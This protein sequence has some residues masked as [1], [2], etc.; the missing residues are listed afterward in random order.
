MGEFHYCRYDCRKW[1]VELQKMKAGGVTVLST[2]LL[3]I[4]HEEEESVFDFSGNWDLRQ[5]VLLAQKVGLEVMLRIGGWAH[6]EC[7]NGG[8]PDWLVQKGI[9]LRQNDPAYLRQIRKWYGEIYQQ[10]QGLM[11]YEGGNIMGIQLDNELTDRLDHLA[12]LKKIT[13][14]I[15]FRVPLY[16]PATEA[17]IPVG[18]VLAVFGAYCEGP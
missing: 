7:R 5:F 14:E 6:G 2:Y 13:R 4:Y 1:E 12:E 3:W 10:V 16:G 17:Q 18:E 9:P 8:F 11:F 15:G